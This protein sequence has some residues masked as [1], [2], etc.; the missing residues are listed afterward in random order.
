MPTVPHTLLGSTGSREEVESN[1]LHSISST[2]GITCEHVSPSG[3]INYVGLSTSVLDRPHDME[4]Y[5]EIVADSNK[6]QE[7]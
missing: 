4:M 5:Y 7:R 6:L 2:T 1:R 3:P